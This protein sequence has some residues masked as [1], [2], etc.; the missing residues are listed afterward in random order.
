MVSRAGAQLHPLRAYLQWWEKNQAGERKEQGEK[1]TKMRW[2]RKVSHSV[3][4]AG[5]HVG[6][7]FVSESTPLD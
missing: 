2:W 3:S 6:I 7:G 1:Q 5:N 4:V